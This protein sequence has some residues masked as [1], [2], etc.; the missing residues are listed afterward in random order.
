MREARIAAGFEDA[1]KAAERFGWNVISYRS[2]ENGIRGIK[3]TVGKAYAK[4]FKVSQAWLMTGEGLM[5]S[6]GID[7]EIMDLPPAISAEVMSDIR[8][9]IAAAKVKGRISK[10]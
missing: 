7:A 3:P 2:H 1:T 6:P 9:L 4:A 5:N 8:K 10:G